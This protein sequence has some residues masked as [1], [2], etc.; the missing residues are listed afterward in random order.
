MPESSTFH[1]RIPKLF[2]IFVGN[3]F[4]QDAEEDYI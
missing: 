1:L 2:L 3:Y 4:F